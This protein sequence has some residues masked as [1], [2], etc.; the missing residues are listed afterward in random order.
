MKSMKKH[1]GFNSSES[2]EGLSGLLSVPFLFCVSGISQTRASSSTVYC[3]L[4]SQNVQVTGISWYC[5][6]L[7]LLGTVPTWAL[8]LA[9]VSGR[10]T[11]LM[12]SQLLSLPPYLPHHHHHHH[13]GVSHPGHK[14][15]DEGKSRAVRTSLTWDPP[16]RKLLGRLLLTLTH[17]VT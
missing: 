1:P 12:D 5:S 9:G 14:Q 11:A 13:S 8:S 17:M 15:E 3:A 16:A 2:G 6:A 10:M 7:L 4:C